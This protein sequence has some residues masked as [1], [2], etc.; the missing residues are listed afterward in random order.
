ME[1]PVIWAPP[2]DSRLFVVGE[3][4]LH[5]VTAGGAIYGITSWNFQ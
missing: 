2:A 3:F 5:A 1:E 4:G